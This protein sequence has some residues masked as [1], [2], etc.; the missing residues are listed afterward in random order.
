MG[1]NGAAASLASPSRAGPPL[2]SPLFPS[3]SAA[4]LLESRA[5][6]AWRGWARPPGPRDRRRRGAQPHWRAEQVRRRQP[7]TLRSGQPARERASWVWILCGS[8]TLEGKKPH[9]PRG[10]L[11]SLFPSSIF[12]LLS[13]PSLPFCCR[14]GG[15]PDPRGG[16]RRLLVLKSHHSLPGVGGKGGRGRLL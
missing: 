7:P 3:R 12:P 6:R 10:G 13:L 15:H 5:G 14:G 2:L 1:P 9:C 8:T 16:S 11:A 4:A